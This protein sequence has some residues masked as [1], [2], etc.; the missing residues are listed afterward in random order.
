MPASDSLRARVERALSQF[1]SP[2]GGGDVLSRGMIKDV[3]TD[4]AGTVTFAFLPGRDDPGSLAR[5]VR[6]AVQGIDGV[7]AVRVNVA[8]ASAARGRVSPGQGAPRAAPGAVPPPP[9]PVE[10]LHLGKVLAISS[11]KGGFGKS[12]VSAH[13]AVALARG[14]PPR[15]AHGC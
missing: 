10:L 7:T 6:K 5:E 13:L 15:G 8:E 4:D 9:T 14:G 12:T 2:R 11:G 3:T 1:K